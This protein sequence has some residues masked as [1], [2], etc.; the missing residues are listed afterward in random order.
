MAW[1]L[2]WDEIY[3][4]QG[5]VQSDVL[6]TAIMAA[7]L[8]KKENIKNVLDLGCGMGRHSVFFAKQGFDVTATDISEKGVE[9]TQQKAAALQL[10]I[11]TACHD[12]RDIPYQK[13]VCR[14]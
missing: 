3:K 11:K 14:K 2:D 10:N 4:T 7:E 13:V 9:E 6:P 8:F 12:M 1:E 5:E